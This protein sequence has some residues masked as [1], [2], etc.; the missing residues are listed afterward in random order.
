MKSKHLQIVSGISPQL[1]WIG[2]YAWDL[3]LY[4]LLTGL[5]MSAFFVYGK[6]S[7]SVFTETTESTMAMFLLILLYGVS[8]L[9]LSY[10]YSFMF[11]NY[12]TAQISIMAINFGTGF[13][14]VLAILIMQSLPETQDA[15]KVMVH[16]FR[17]FPPYLIGEG[18][19]NLATTYYLNIYF[20][21][22]SFFAW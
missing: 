18:F 21:P 22:Q 3:M 7:A 10:I 11:T 17:V 20:Q 1:Y 9:P 2:T 4:F 5:A 19:I 14:S 12:S 13:V 6:D 15:A 8:S 16:V